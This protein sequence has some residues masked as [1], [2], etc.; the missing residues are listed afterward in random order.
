MADGSSG[1]Q[2]RLPVV[3]KPAQ[4]V[5][6]ALSAS[7]EGRTRHVR[8]R[9][10]KA[11]RR[12]RQPTTPK[13][14]SPSSSVAG[15]PRLPSSSAP[16]LPRSSTCLQS[17]R[18]SAERAG[19]R[20]SAQDYASRARLATRRVSAR[21]TSR[22]RAAPAPC[23]ARGLL[24]P[25]IRRRRSGSYQK[26]AWIATTSPAQPGAASRACG[27]TTKKILGPAW[28][29]SAGLRAQR[30]GHARARSARTFGRRAI[31]SRCDR[32]ARRSPKLARGKT[33]PVD[34][35]CREAPRRSCEFQ[36]TVD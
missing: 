30:N 8:R 22:S 5:S 28:R 23:A 12:G 9:L 4:P 29:R 11:T 13:G 31:S 34:E 19:G 36:E 1:K 17:W 27:A 20:A 7:F 2:R 35:E 14:G 24:A 15:P 10:G 32:A 6:C 26:K 21:R 16:P 33:P 18:V 25:P 3:R